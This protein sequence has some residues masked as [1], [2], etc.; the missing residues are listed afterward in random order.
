LRVE[1]VSPD[2]GRVGNERVLEKE[3]YVFLGEKHQR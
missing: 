1:E 3:I 2:A